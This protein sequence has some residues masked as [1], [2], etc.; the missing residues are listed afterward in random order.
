ME[1]L[2]IPCNLT[3]TH[4]P[5]TKQ[6]SYS[7]FNTNRAYRSGYS[8]SLSPGMAKL[9]DTKRCN[10]NFNNLRTNPLTCPTNNKSSSPY[11]QTSLTQS[12]CTKTN[13]YCSNNYSGSV[14]RVSAI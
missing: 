7:S 2:K 11:G 13:S 10:T 14:A 3:Y 8:H 12:N 5:Q 6:M 1:Y 4:L 9:I